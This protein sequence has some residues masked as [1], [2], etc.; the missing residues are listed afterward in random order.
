M[1]TY[2]SWC[3]DL[4]QCVSE[5]VQIRGY[6]FCG[7]GIWESVYCVGELVVI[8][9]VIGTYFCGGG[10]WGRVEMIR[11][12]KIF[13][14]IVVLTMVKLVIALYNFNDYDTAKQL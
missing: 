2:F 5:L 10:I 9:V 13:H 7:V 6:F 4:K 1:G 12:W 14:K 11:N 3:W 8:R